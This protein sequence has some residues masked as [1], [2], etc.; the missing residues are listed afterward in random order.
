M[1]LVQFVGDT[2]FHTCR[3]D[4]LT[5][6]NV[7][8]RK[9]CFY[10][11]EV[12]YKSRDYERVINLE[13]NLNQGFPLFRL[14]SSD[15]SRALDCGV[16]VS[17]NFESRHPTSPLE[18]YELATGDMLESTPSP[19]F[20][21]GH[22]SSPVVNLEDCL[23]T[24]DMSEVEVIC[25]SIAKATTPDFESSHQASPVRNIENSDSSTKDKSELVCGSKIKKVT[26]SSSKSLCGSK[27]KENT[28]SSSGPDTGICLIII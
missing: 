24:G 16:A 4:S 11:V 18:D 27:N 17:S 20:Q 7:L 9:G 21:N 14:N 25:G 28:P 19:G 26:P 2:C 5:D 15:V 12:L 3:L 6:Q 1:F 22:Q 13:N 8:K 23:I 10:Q